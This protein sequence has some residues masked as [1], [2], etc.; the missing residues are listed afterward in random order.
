[1]QGEKNEKV[2]VKLFQKLAERE[3]ASRDLNR[4]SRKKKQA[5]PPHAAEG[6]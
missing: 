3:T 1:M 6:R 2:L 4:R 5:M